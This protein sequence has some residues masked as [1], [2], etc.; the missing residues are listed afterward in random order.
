MVIDAGQCPHGLQAGLQVF[1]RLGPPKAKTSYRS[2]SSRFKLMHIN[3]FISAFIH[4][5]TWFCVG[6]RKVQYAF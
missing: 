3:A 2:I 4:I 5:K 6:G 1:L